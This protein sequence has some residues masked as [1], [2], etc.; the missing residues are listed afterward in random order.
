MT[1]LKASVRDSA[2]DAKQGGQA[3]R[4]TRAPKARTPEPKEIVSGAG[5]P[6]DPGVRRELE[7]RLG[8]DLSR[9][10]VHTDRDSAALTELIGA[11]AVAVGPD[12]FFGEGKYR[13]AA[14]DGRRLLTHELLHTIQAPNPLGALRAG[15]DLGAVSLPQDAVERE[16]EQGAAEGRPTTATPSAT[17]GWLRYAT[18]DADRFRTERLDP[19]TLVDRLASGILRS[20]RG[21]PTDSSG[22]VRLQLAR[23][24]PELQSSVLDRLADLLPSSDYTRVLEL[25]EAAEHRP[26]DV[27]AAQ[28]PE[29]V[30][31]AADRTTDD[32]DRTDQEDREERDRKRQLDDEAGKSDDPKA[33]RKH[34]RHRKGHGDQEGEDAKGDK[35]DKD[36]GEER[37]DQQDEQQDGQ[38]DE[39]QTPP[40]E[41]EAAQP[42]AQPEAGQAQLPA[43]AQ[44]SAVEEAPAAGA[45]QAPVAAEEGAVQPV[46]ASALG[47]PEA[48]QQ[49]VG[50]R[51]SAGTKPQEPAAGP[52][53]QP[54]P[55]KPERL[56]AI[57]RA[58]DSPL[59][60]HGLLEG[61]HQQREAPDEERPLG[62]EPGADSEVHDAPAA[63][64]ERQSSATPEP[65]L[66]PGDFLPSADLDVSAVPTADQL[67]L[68]ADGTPP[69]QAEA[70]EFPEPPATKA[71]Q[72]QAERDS[73]PEDDAEA[74]PAPSGQAQPEPAQPGAAPQAAPEPTP[75][76]EAEDRSARDLQ[77][78]QPVEQE[79]GP[80]PTAN[81]AAAPA[82]AEPTPPEAPQ[83]EAPAEA[84]REAEPAPETAS[85]AAPETA[86]SPEPGGPDRT[87]P[88]TPGPVDG[89]GP[90]GG[91]GAVL[92][93]APG[94]APGATPDAALDAAPGPAAEQADASG[95][96]TAQA[97]PDAS[98]EAGGGTCAGPQ[99]PTT[100]AEQDGTGGAG[101]GCAAGGGGGAAAGGAQGGQD[102]QQKPA[103]PDVSGQD[104]QSALATAASLPPDQMAT[105]LDGV[106]GSVDRTVGEQH[107][108]LQAAP[109][110]AQRPSG[111]PQTQS[112]APEAA[113]PAEAVTERLE[114]VG[115]QGADGGQQTADQKK[116]EGRNP[117]DRVA[118]PNVADDAGNQ[119]SAQEVQQAQVAVDGVPST[120]PALNTTVGP[121]P[122]VELTGESDPARTDHQAAK[123]KESS[124]RI[125]G[126]GREDTAKPMGEDR[127]YPDV[128][129]ETLTASVPG[130]GGK[131]GGA[132]AGGAVDTKPGIGIVTQQERGPQIQAAVGEGQ[133]RLG[134]EQSK[135]KQG[136]AEARRQ[137][138][139]E[140]D[141]AVA[142]NAQ[143]QA[144]ER[145][146]AA[147]K[148]KAEREQWRTEQ[149]GK[150]STADQDA[151]AEHT[152]KTGQIDRKRAGADKD[153][154]DRRQQD[155]QKI[156]DKRKEAEEKA[157]KEKDRKK[158]ESEGW[159][160]WV[161]SKVKAAFDALVEAVTKVFD[162]FR[163][164]INGIIDGFRTFANWAIDQARKF[165]VELIDKLADAL[166]RICD[167]LLAAFPELR[168]KFR[169]KIEEWR[170]KA[171]AKVNEWADRLKNAV[172][173]LLDALAAGL[174]ALL[175]ALE[176]GL[177]AAIEAVRKAVMD[178]IDFVQKAIAVFGEFAAL[179][180]DIAPDPG[181]WLKKLGTAAVDGIQHYLW[182]AIK[183]AVRT[184]F[185][186]KVESVV[187][188]TS[189]LVNVLV[190][191][192][193]SMAQIGRMAWQA[194]VAALPGMI[195]SIVV[196]KL[197]S[198]IVPA[199]GAIMAIIQGLMAAWNTISKIIAAIGKFVAF[200]KAVK[201]GSAACLFADAVAAGVVALLDFISN[202]LLSKLKGAGKAV[203]T[204]LRGIAQRILKGLA[205][206]GRGAR[207]A[208][209]RAVNKAR[210]SLRRATQS[211]RRRPGPTRP[212]RPARTG[213]ARHTVQHA[214][215]RP[216]ATT[217]RPRRE[218]TR[219][220]P[221]APRR[222]TSPVGRAL[223][224][225]RQTVKAALNRVRTAARTL[226]RKLLNSKLGRAL[227]NGAHRI[228]DAYRKQRDRLRA[229]HQKRQQQRAQ[230]RARE[231][232][233][234]A[235][236]QRLAA[237]LARLRPRLHRLL[238]RGLPDKVLSAV[239]RAL[240]VWYRLTGLDKVGSSAFH[241]LAK[242]NPQE[243]AVD[244]IDVDIADRVVLMI[245]K[246]GE[247]YR[248][249]ALQANGGRALPEPASAARDTS[250]LGQLVSKGNIKKRQTVERFEVDVAQTPYQAS[251]MVQSIPARDAMNIPSYVEYRDNDRILAS[252][253]RDQG[254]SYSGKVQREDQLV[255]WTW[256]EGDTLKS[257]ALKHNEWTTKLENEWTPAERRALATSALSVIS[258]GR[259]E[260]RHQQ[261]AAELAQWHFQVEGGRDPATF[262][263]T[264]MGLDMA[265][266]GHGQLK[267]GD[268]EVD[269]SDLLQFARDFPMR[270]LKAKKIRKNLH[271][272][273][274]TVQ[275]HW[276]N[277]VGARGNP[278]KRPL[279][280]T[281]SKAG[282][283]KSDMRRRQLRIFRAW[284]A[285]VDDLKAWA[286]ELEGLAAESPQVVEARL[287]QL[288]KLIRARLEK[289]W[290]KHSGST[291]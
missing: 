122:K 64:E 24:A 98:L 76:T 10:R 51:P 29:P 60:R 200:L 114:R 87:A 264:T 57:A 225:S 160:G 172:N 211:L 120:D 185:N 137:N 14:E 180:G 236:Q 119:V 63:G 129:K 262:A 31:D 168:D 283:E 274:E 151:G 103:P 65:E 83:P 38:Q 199:A 253:R 43:E 37:P 239:L 245:N 4:K 189:T 123:L 263:L 218:T 50:T 174:N 28:T 9:V 212:A 286:K 178:A 150:I 254:P 6:L 280:N 173:K 81:P 164:L 208:A 84:A 285:S 22:R 44:P 77:P 95:G 278:L 194:I 210:A 132:G 109:P 125:L 39:Q 176:A 78:E 203:G 23:F 142:D 209:G 196:E 232:S 68:S 147:E 111:A 18:V 79:I 214:E 272:H 20:L 235:K 102:Q 187:G 67:T 288:E 260:G 175:D 157:Q 267:L 227:T 127:I 181:G 62:M 54:S 42:P 61:D 230:R 94:A 48:E 92:D 205:R 66:K 145:G 162:F 252:V 184:W 291:T 153:V 233:P 11:D 279:N 146:D 155:N 242:L 188:L 46:V 56:D 124:G 110:T 243:T 271:K 270:E 143:A 255:H 118:P 256:R 128:P 75:A 237:I 198:M 112:G 141:Q 148:V 228:R 201:S 222:P 74:A 69:A 91:D 21:D 158:E 234:E 130:G 70:P 165:A 149:D 55:V 223:N 159:W 217:G 104:P 224:S 45:E 281:D 215:H 259:P 202:F 100:E 40:A 220:K 59:A 182:G 219:P 238:G 80:E 101:G 250:E 41:G 33:R 257:A 135:Q 89:S 58:E 96:L 266:R 116:V 27:D 246:I 231:N 140:V 179:I 117:G 204:K 30:T 276:D 192:C 16:A 97:A 113:P 244:G 207:K 183:S 156:Q 86:A 15:R 12:L 154:Q 261:N 7:A 282:Q 52:L 35:D 133:G 32:R 139:A 49:G 72:V 169:K 197:V 13:P 90:V 17:P 193:I 3:R 134:S 25:V 5:Q 167:V 93:S 190:K 216:T 226:G 161:K 177:K 36:G 106:D 107:A 191:G 248:A 249:R 71:D 240:R 108:R 121:A 195:V 126:V 85:E 289:L 229:W 269:Y 2:Q 251:G 268:E 265:S 82:P 273:M 213:P 221:T 186:E 284:L 170:D 166:I 275:K 241:V 115:P 290:E 19:A 26:A 99:Q 144:G 136:E 34:R 88:A 53:P 258:G 73:R 8:H 247:E 105:T 277:P 152:D 131:G 206:A 171:I 287:A 47:S 138:Q 1:Q 163:G